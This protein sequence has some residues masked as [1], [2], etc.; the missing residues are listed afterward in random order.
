MLEREIQDPYSTSGPWSTE[1]SLQT[2]KP[3]P[4]GSS[5]ALGATATVSLVVRS[6]WA[7]HLSPCSFLPMRS[8]VASDSQIEPS[9]KEEEEEEGSREGGKPTPHMPSN[10]PTGQSLLAT[11]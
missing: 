6:P 5:G 3:S 11:L 7:K 8:I 4:S 1:G 9:K 10:S 2:F